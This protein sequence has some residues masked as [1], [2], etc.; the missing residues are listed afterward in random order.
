MP[1]SRYAERTIA[2]SS[3]PWPRFPRRFA[4]ARTRRPCRT[5]SARSGREVRRSSSRAFAALLVA[6]ALMEA[7][8]FACLLARVNLNGGVDALALIPTTLAFLG[9]TL[10]VVAALRETGSEARG[11][12]VVGATLGVGLIVA[13]LLP[14]RPLDIVSWGGRVI[15]FLI[16]AEVY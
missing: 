14:T 7:I 1:R 16:L 3:C 2:S 8:A 9:A 15:G 11:A 13:V 12:T 6:R 4:R 10:V 5:T